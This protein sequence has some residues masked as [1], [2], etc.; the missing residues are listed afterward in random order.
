MP[1]DIAEYQLDY[2]TMN[3][4]L[5]PN[6]M[7]PPL[8][9]LDNIGAT[10][11]MNATLQCFSN[12][13]QFVTFFKYDPYLINKIKNDDGKKTLSS[14]FKLLIEKLW[15]N[16]YN[17]NYYKKTYSPYEF[18]YKI[19][20]MN[21]LFKGVHANDSK[22][23]VNFIIMTLHEEL[24]TIKYPI[25][26]NIINLDQTN[27]HLMFSTF[28]QNFNA[29][30]KSK[31]SELFYAFNYNIT[32]CQNCSTKSYNFQT[33]F[34]LI[35]PLEEVR[36]YK[37]SLNQFGNF[38]NI[39]NMN[40][41]NIFDGFDYERKITVMSGQNAMYCNYCRQTC[42]SQMCTNLCTGPNILIIILNR[43]KGIEFNVKINFFEDLNLERYIGMPQTGCYYK[44]IGVITHIGESGM[45]GH[46]IAYCK[47]PINNQWNK[48]NDSIVSPVNDFKSE[49]IDFAMPYLLF[50]QK[51]I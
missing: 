35:F 19:S 30:N 33:Y 47:N 12:I 32:Q 27:M 15:P 50:Y 31:I 42:D 46:F 16:N 21:P 41:V 24:N 51:Q 23:L 20:K 36:K 26:D 2:Q 3:I 8:I 38:N 29:T 4:A 11:Y 43:G 37:L 34:F 1:V 14:S 48:Y 7:N 39:Y 6:F 44:L 49:V 18:K 28:T 45:G 9:G 40:E 10:C 17:I 5:F 25:V 22:D 13:G